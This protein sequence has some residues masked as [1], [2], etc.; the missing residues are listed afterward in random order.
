SGKTTLLHVLGGLIV[1]TRG[2]VEWRGAPSSTLDAAARGRQRARE[3]GFVFQGAN[4]LPT[5]TAFENVSF[6]AW[7]AAAGRGEGD[8]PAHPEELLAL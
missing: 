6:A 7:A 8:T 2:V 4:L 1:P 5:L 3:I